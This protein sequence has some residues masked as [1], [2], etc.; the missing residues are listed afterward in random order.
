MKL[1]YILLIFIAFILRNGFTQP[2]EEWTQRYNGS[3][4]SFDI[5]SKMLFDNDN[6]VYIFGSSS[7]TG[8]GTDFLII[9]YSPEGN[10]IWTELYDGSGNS[11]DHINSACLSNTGDI[12]ITGYTTDI[13]FRTQLTTAKFDS[14]GNF[15]WS[16]LFSKPGYVIGNGKDIVLDNSNNILVCGSIKREVGFFDIE[17]IKY[18]PDG[19][20]IWSNTFNGE[21]N[22]D[23]NPVTLKNDDSDNI[24]VAG[25]TKSLLTDNDMIIIKYDSSSN[26]IW[27]KTYNG[28]ADLADVMSDMVLDTENNIY[29]CG[30]KFNTQSSYDYFYAKLDENGNT[31]WSGDFNGIG[32][33]I[34]IPSSIIL[35]SSE[36]VY[37]SGFSRAG[38]DLGSEDFLTIKLDQEGNTDWIRSFNGT[39]DGMDQANSIAVDNHGNVYVGGA[40]DIG[41]FHLVY[42]LIKYDSLGSFM[43]E[44]NYYNSQTPE[45]FIYDIA[46]DNLNNI[47]VTGISFSAI[48]DFDIAT[49]KY[50][51][52]VG[53][54]QS[55]FNLPDKFVLR[56]NYPN[57]FNPSTVIGYDLNVS[58]FVSLIIYDI[59][60][61]K[62]ASLV[63]EYKETGTYETLW[64]ASDSPNGIYFYEMKVEEYS[65]VKKMLLIK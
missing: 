51:Q 65:S 11:F 20:E 48:T 26:L 37:I 47:Y 7:E 63:N 16:K 31:L 41:E 28:T 9:K 23:D 57:P 5:V 60:G 17:L 4:N 21:G 12:Y 30:N 50:S 55:Q 59:L 3:A 43:W 45:D 34:D 24:I 56:Q 36:N 8:S 52:T 14:S 61:K 15:I 10:I 25:T 40:S 64:N 49:I 27:K 62:I 54:D 1:K 19:D 2:V 38:V 42:S 6:N 39:S 35:D 53:I 33:N 22:G 13:A 29:F 32:N 44:K 46:L 18:S 58:G